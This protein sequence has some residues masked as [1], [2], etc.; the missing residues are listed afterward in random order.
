MSWGGARVF[1]DVLT[2]S[3][4]LEADDSR[5]SCFGPL[6]EGQGSAGARVIRESWGQKV[7]AKGVGFVRSTHEFT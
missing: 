1:H 5:L 4:L 6:A 3:Y 7:E 2:G